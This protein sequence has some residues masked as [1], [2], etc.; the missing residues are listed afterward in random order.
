MKKLH[1]IL[2]FSLLLIIPL[3]MTS[4][5]YLLTKTGTFL[6]RDDTP[7]RGDA[8]VVLWG[9]DYYSRLVE[10]ARLYREG[11]TPKVVINGNRKSTVEILL[12]KQGLQRVPWYE[13]YV[14]TLVFLGTPRHDII[15]I[16]AE[17]AYDTV[18]ES[19][20]VGQQL[21]EM[22]LSDLIVTTSKFHSRRAGFIWE[23]THGDTFSIRMAPADETPFTPSGWWKDG[24]QIRWVLSEY[25]AWLYYCWKRLL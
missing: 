16:S 18:S 4:G 6:V 15:T 19:E 14:R 10:A 1:R 8:A 13:N 20:L 12:E 5:K 9:S 3:M 11:K 17:E 21:R 25:G 7:V 24:R 22:Q 23:Q 2:L